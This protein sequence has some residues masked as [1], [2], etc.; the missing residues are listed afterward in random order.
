GARTK[1]RAEH[2]RMVAQLMRDMKQE[3]PEWQAS[4]ERKMS[5]GQLRPE[6]VGRLF[7]SMPLNPLQYQVKKLGV[8]DSMKVWDL[9]SPTERDQLR[10]TVLRKLTTAK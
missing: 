7:R 5:T 10:P 9:A 1:D 8:E 6:E 3:D 4:L 2:S